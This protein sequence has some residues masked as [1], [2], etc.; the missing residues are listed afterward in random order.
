MT[1]N[2]YVSKHLNRGKKIIPHIICAD[3]FHM[4]VQVGQYNYC[5]PRIDGA[6]SYRSMEVGYPSHTEP[7][8]IKY[9]EDMDRPTETV[10]DY[11]P[12]DVIDVVIAE[13]GGMA[14]WF[15]RI[16]TKAWMD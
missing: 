16:L 13:H 15:K 6:D 11:V 10:Y 7:L 14:G 4:S 12:V 3:G 9:A 8:L 5:E 1:I 2:Q